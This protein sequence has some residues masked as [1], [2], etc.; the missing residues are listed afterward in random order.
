MKKVTKVNK[1]EIRAQIKEINTDI[2]NLSKT[3]AVVQKT[4][5]K[6]LNMLERTINKL[7][8]KRER[9][10]SVIAGVQQG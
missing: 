9:L 8:T 2:R 10:D 1:G 3:R 6:E 5:D 4:A 7:R